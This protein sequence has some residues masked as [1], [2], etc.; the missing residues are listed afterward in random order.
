MG[1]SLAKGRIPPMPARAVETA[2]CAAT[3]T[4]RRSADEVENEVELRP[5]GVVVLELHVTAGVA[6]RT[7][8][9]GDRD[10]AVRRVLER[11]LDG[12]LPAR[13]ERR[14]HAFPGLADHGAHA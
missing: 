12:D 13:Q 3:A 7:R 2:K 8:A 10:D 11:T 5:G 9:A 1:R 4:A 6:I 14:P